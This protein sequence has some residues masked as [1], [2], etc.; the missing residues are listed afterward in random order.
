MTTKADFNAEEWGRV[1]QGPATAGLM[2]ITAQRGGTLR[3]T[4]S[5]AK[6]YAEAQKE[7]GSDDLLGELVAAAPQIDRGA[8][9]SAEDLQT[10]APQV[11][12]EAVAAL[13][14]HATPDEV[15]A[16]KR[17]C[18]T[19][20]EHAAERTKS[21]GFLGIGGKRISESESAALDQL[22]TTLGIERM[23]SGPAPAEG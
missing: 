23:E 13:E 15:E 20:A 17:F 9:S 22:A 18:L 10:R 8:F 19:V 1:Q 4:V 21:G 11:I 6:T 3:E 2:V 5:M 14:A 12:G 7:H 16:Y